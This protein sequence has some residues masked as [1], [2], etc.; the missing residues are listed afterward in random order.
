MINECPCESSEWCYTIVALN[1]HPERSRGRE[2]KFDIKG[3]SSSPIR[4][5]VRRMTYKYE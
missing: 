3:Q 5:T 4:L 1:L 2:F